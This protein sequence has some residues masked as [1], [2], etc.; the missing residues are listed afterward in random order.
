M[1]KNTFCILNGIGERIERRLWK[2]GI[3]TWED[4]LST[5]E[6]PFINKEQKISY[7]SYL[8]TASV[9][10]KK[11]NAEYFA[12]TIKR[13]EHWRLYDIF[14]D[15][16]IC[17]DIETNGYMPNSGGYITII[18]LYDGA[19]YK[20]FIKGIN[21][22]CEE[23]KKALSGY[24][25]LIT[26]Y[27]AVFDIPYIQKTISNIDFNLLH[28]DL[29]LSA[30]RIGLKGGLKRLEKEF[31]ILRDEPVKDMDGY[32]AV[33][34]WEYARQGSKE[35]LELLLLYNREDTVNLFKLAE[36]IYL[37]LRKLTGIE[38]YL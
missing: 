8:K 30:K 25:Y 13:R 38:E 16:T 29:C 9:E 27:G 12:K 4:F 6:L 33:R 22:T 34:L 17:L 21:L 26:F 7:D 2:N 35:A 31:G 10:L 24:K 3:L 20:S 32:D 23:I 15:K 14:K 37:Q 28:F 36:I 19:N 18:G 1:I 5:S 11:D